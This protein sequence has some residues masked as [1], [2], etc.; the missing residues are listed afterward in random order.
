MGLT[1]NSTGAGALDRGLHIVRQSAQDL[2]IALAGN[3]NVGKS[4]VFNGLTGMHQ[5]TGNWPGKTVANAQGTCVHNGLRTILVDL[6]GTYSLIPLSAEEEVA[7]DFL[8]FG[9]A[10]AAIVVCDATCLVRNLN[11][12][13][14]TMEAIG[15]VVVCVNLL[16]EAK[17]NHIEIDLQ[18]LA[19]RLHTPVVGTTARQKRGLLAILEAAQQTAHQPQKEPLYIPYPAPIE[20]ALGPLAAAIS[21]AYSGPGPGARWLGLQLLMGEESVVVAMQQHPCGQILQYQEVQQALQTARSMLAQHGLAPDA[22]RDAIVQSV[23]HMAENLCMGVVHKKN[24]HSRT[25]ARFDRIFTRRKTAIPLMLGLLAVVFFLT[26]WG[27]NYP[28]QLLSTALFWL[29]DR[30]TDLFAV[31][32]AP[33]WLHG[34][35]VMGIYRTLAW[36]VSVMLPPMAIFFPLF[37]ILEDWGLLPRIA[38]NLDHAFH[39]CRACGKQALTMCLGKSARKG[40]VS[41][42]SHHRESCAGALLHTYKLYPGKNSTP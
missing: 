13:L 37:T 27:A 15:Q 19:A 1:A 4:T 17:R 31:L 25:G 40:A 3:P 29:Q 32:Q 18:A 35:L 2:V 28:S 26:I 10:D 33:A 14:Q 7:R 5:H 16:D 23:Y 36:V 20:D 42:L 24:V 38:F 8:C 39:R 41:H 12:V 9:E 30:L 6:P 11:L 22:L 21:R 34:I